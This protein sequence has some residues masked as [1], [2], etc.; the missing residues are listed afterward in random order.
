MR[1]LA[2]I[3]L[4][5][6]L[7]A[8]LLLPATGSA[9]KPFTFF[10]S[11]FGHGLGM[12]QWGAYGMALDGSA[13]GGIL[14]HFY[15][16]THVK[17]ASDPPATL[18]IGLT[19]SQKKIRVE[20]IAG[21]TTLRVG[22][23]NNG[24]LVGEIPTG[25]QWTVRVHAKKYR[26]FDAQGDRVGDRDWGG[27]AN[28]L[29]ATYEPD[30]ARVHVPEGGAT[31]NRGYLEFNLYSCGDG[32]CQLRLILPVDP[33]GYLYGLAE[34]PSS[35]PPSALRAQAVAARTYAFSK[36]A[37]GQH[38]KPCNCALYDSSLDQVYSGWNKEGGV[39][40]DLWVDAVDHTDEKVVV[41]QG[42]LIQAF[43]A[44]SSG[45]YT[46]NNENVWG[47]APIAW[48]RGVCDPGDYTGANPNAVWEET[49]SAAKLKSAL[50]PYTGS[51][52]I[53]KGFA[54]YKRGVSG[55]IESVRVNGGQ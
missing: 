30:G 51:I 17:K 23:R 18:R 43:Y 36:A 20:S 44:S 12:S 8:A 45:G 42:S 47:G 35:W 32:A 53:V 14:R 7:A 48:L 10:G 1:R 25:D 54:N 41:Y 31:Y 28:D 5:L 2:L 21:P 3:S 46:E 11:G 15:S 26:V 38:R 24:P 55:R 29:F 52:G 16:G 49:F 22:N 39:D 34:V 33:Q 13:Y 6:A 40:G 37:N 19:Q 50:L 27:T 4:V 9:A